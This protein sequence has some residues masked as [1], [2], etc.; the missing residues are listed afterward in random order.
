MI[1]AP[2]SPT[3][4]VTSIAWVTSA[5]VLNPSSSYH[6]SASV[7]TLPLTAIRP[8]DGLTYSSTVTSVN[9]ST[10]NPCP[11]NQECV[12]N[13]GN[14]LTGFCI[15]PRGFI[16]TSDGLC[17]D[18]N[19]CEQQTFPC[20]PGA[21]CINTAGSFKCSCPPTNSGDPYGEGCFGK[22]LLFT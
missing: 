4:L 20:G 8:N 13:G 22:S 21:Q 16:L 17:R 3:V 11:Q 7:S 12:Y 19:E 2:A 14:D 9:C 1:H 6:R 15:C 10:S 5:A 18:I